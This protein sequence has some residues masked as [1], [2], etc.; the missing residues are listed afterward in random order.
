MPCSEFFC[1]YC[2]SWQDRRIVCTDEV[3]AFA[4]VNENVLLDAIP[5]SE[6]TNI[7]LMNAIEQDKQQD[8]LSKGY[9][10]V[11]D[12]THAFQIRTKKDGQNAGRKYVLRAHSDDEVA[13]IISHLNHLAKKAAKKAA[14]R[15]RWE[16]MQQR[17]RSV[18]S[19]TWFQGI[20]AF[21]IIAVWM[22]DCIAAAVHP[23]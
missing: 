2:R 13:S 11:I 15:T 9:G 8:Q 10:T 5:L 22:T 21:L 7:D 23:D 16:K 4:R 3:I 14:A 19:A 17:V 18:Y 12:F 20:S 1:S 6:V